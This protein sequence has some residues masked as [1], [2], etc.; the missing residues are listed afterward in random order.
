MNKDLIDVGIFLKE[1]FF[2]SFPNHDYD[3]VMILPTIKDFYLV[4]YNVPFCNKMVGSYERFTMEVI[5]V[6]ILYV[7]EK[8]S[9]GYCKNNATV[10]LQERKDDE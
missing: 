8:Y 5:S 2:D 6:D 4:P 1:V 3:V 10:Y 9:V 7:N